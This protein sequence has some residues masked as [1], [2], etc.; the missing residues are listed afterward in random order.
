MLAEE[1]E[2]P[3]G[4][5]RDGTSSGRGAGW[6]AR[7]G[8]TLTLAMAGLGAGLTGC[9]AAPEGPSMQPGKPITG[10]NLSGKWYS[11]EFG[12]MQIQQDKNQITG[13]YEDPRGPDHNGRLRG[14]INND[15]LEIEWIK[16]GNPAAAVMP[17]R[18]Q[19]KLRIL[20]RGCKVDGL[21]GYDE[22]WYGGGAWRADKSQF[23]AGGELCGEATAPAKKAAPPVVPI[24]DGTTEEVLRESL[25]K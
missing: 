3:M 24:D 22:D 7:I 19:A 1:R 2:T 16:P 21:W 20:D 9:G 5:R 17:M 13:K 6:T 18:G 11:R 25:P 10:L 23:A 14:R 4:E 15:V 8:L 12:D